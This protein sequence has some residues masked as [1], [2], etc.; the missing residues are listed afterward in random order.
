MAPV[1]NFFT[2]DE[3][4]PL[5][6]L[7]RQLEIQAKGLC[8]NL[9]LIWPDIKDSKWIGGNREGWER[10]PYW[11]DGFIPLAYLLEDKELISRAKRFIDKP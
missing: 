7:R 10:L 9:D 8:G 1:F 5:G 6:W 4:K 2:T 3:I 11:L